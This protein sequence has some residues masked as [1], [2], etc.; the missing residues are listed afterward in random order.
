MKIGIIGAMEVEVE[1]LKQ[2]LEGRRAVSRASMEFNEGSLGGVPVV[3]V[4][5]GI[6]KVNAGVCAQILCDLFDVTH[7]INTGVAGSLDNAINIGDV[8]VS[9]DA[10]HHDMD[11]T[12]LGYAPG[13]VPGFDVLAFPANVALRE[14]AVAAVEAV[15][16]EIA[17]FEGRVAS[18]DQFIHGGTQKEQIINTFGGLCAEMEGASI[19]HACWL[20]D[21]PFVIVRAISDKADGSSTVEYPV[22]EREAAEHCAKI[23]E[24]MVAQLGA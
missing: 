17:V 1:H 11:V 10:V 7:V 14:Q 4:K 21:V 6:G 19:A 8:V 9:T 13:H 22:F 18:G 23:V 3:V 2:R 15:A 20:N 16:P 12:A 24:H 5:C